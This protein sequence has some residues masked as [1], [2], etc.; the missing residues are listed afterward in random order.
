MKK[1]PVTPHDDPFWMKSFMNIIEELDDW[2]HLTH[3]KTLRKSKIDLLSGC[4]G[5][6]PEAWVCQA[7]GSFANFSVMC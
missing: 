6:L 7:P 5:L 3:D 1:V 2:D 4:S